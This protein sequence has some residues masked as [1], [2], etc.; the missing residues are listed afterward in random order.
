MLVGVAT[1]ALVLVVPAVQAMEFRIA[2]NEL[3][4]RGPVKGY[5]YGLFREVTSAHPEIDTVVLRD[6]PGGDGWSAL[7]VAERIRDAGMRTVLAGRC[8]SACAYMFLGGKERHFVR[9]ARPELVYL[10]FHGAFAG[11]FFDPNKPSQSGRA[12]LR[13]WIVERT[14][15][16][17]DRELMDRFLGAD[18]RA[19]LLYVFDPLQFRT[20]FGFSLY[21]CDGTQPRNAAP[22]RE[23]SKIAGQDAFSLGI[24]NAEERVRVRPPQMLPPPFERKNEPYRWAPEH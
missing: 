17:M 21:F 13:A 14:G 6:S 7:R 23:C 5:E 15:G 2:G 11:D 8:Y 1:L 3:H 16:K 10:A 18:H 12:E 4:L 24:V 20:D 9:A 22:F 19:A